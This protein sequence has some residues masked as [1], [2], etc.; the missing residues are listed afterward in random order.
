MKRSLAS[1][2]YR[3]QNLIYP[4]NKKAVI[5][6]LD[7]YRTVASHRIPPCSHVC[8]HKPHKQPA[9]VNFEVLFEDSI[10]MR[11]CDSIDS[12]ISMLHIEITR[13]EDE[14]PSQEPHCGREALVRTLMSPSR[15]LPPFF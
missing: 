14:I 11:I 12:Q 4:Q 10:S 2:K 5:S 9:K 8:L 13:E 1:S 7:T 15:I 3:N 6:Q